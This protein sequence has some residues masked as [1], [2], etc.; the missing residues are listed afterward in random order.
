MALWHWHH[1]I[2]TQPGIA[3]EKRDESDQCAKDSASSL[4]FSPN[5]L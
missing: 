2:F 4:F 3:Q 5:L 1:R